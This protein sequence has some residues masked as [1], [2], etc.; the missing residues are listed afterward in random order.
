[1]QDADI[2]W[3]KVIEKEYKN[4][5]V[6]G[7]ITGMKLDDSGNGLA[8]A[9]I[10]LYVSSEEGPIAVTVSAD[11]GSFC[12]EDIPYGEYFVKEIE[13]PEG[14]LMDENFYALVIDSDGKVIEIEIVNTLIRGNVQLTKVDEDYPENHLTGAVFEVYSGGA[15]VGQMEE[16]EDGVY[17]L[18]DLAYGDYTLK[19]VKAPEGFWLDE[20]TYTFSIRENGAT[21]VVENEAGAGFINQAQKGNIRIEKTS[22][23][24]VLSGFTFRVTG[25]DAAGNAFSEEYVTDENG[26]IVITGL[27][28]GEYVISEVANEANEQYDLPAD[29]T[30]TVYTDRTVVAKFYNELIPTDIPYTGD[31]TNIAFWGA[32]T[33]GALA[34]AIVSALFTFLKKEENKIS[35]SDEE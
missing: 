14:Y 13:A 31:G 19:E 24:G 17:E 16:L 8:G 22:E 35:G 7:D 12:F 27:R 29:V 23:D 28:V 21:V 26:M 9:V 2:E 32:A 10:G 1:M 34:G 5:L 20:N 25:T 18:S 15:L 11:D 3:N 30:V 6:R 4:M 33:L